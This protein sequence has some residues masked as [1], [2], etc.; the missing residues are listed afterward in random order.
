MLYCSL[1]EDRNLND[2]QRAT[3]TSI[4]GKDSLMI[5]E[6]V[7]N[8]CTHRERYRVYSEKELQLRV[9]AS[10]LPFLV[11]EGAAEHNLEVAG[12]VY[13]SPSGYL[14]RERRSKASKSIPA[15]SNQ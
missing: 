14:R 1:F 10:F 13:S 3:E 8:T 15:I 5:H 2:Q 9:A 12:F 11:H 7:F 6:P 4:T